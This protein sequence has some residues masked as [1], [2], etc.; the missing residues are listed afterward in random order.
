MGSCINKSNEIISIRINE[1]SH[2]TNEP[3]NIKSKKLL[4]GNASSLKLSSLKFRKNKLHFQTLYS[5][6][7]SKILIIPEMIN[8]DNDI[9][10]MNSIR[11]IIELF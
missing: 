11:E 7:I 9:N 2:T 5:N 1:K 8:N 10:N 4:S 6:D 3:T